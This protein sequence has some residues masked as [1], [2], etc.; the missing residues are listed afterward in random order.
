M[1]RRPLIAV[2]GP[3]GTGKTGIALHVAEAVEAEIISVDSRQAYRGM[4][5]GTAAP[6]AAELERVPHHG[7]G[8]LAPG[9]RYGAGRFGRLSR[10]WMA[11][12]R[13]RNREPMLVGGTGF[14][15]RSLVRP[16]FREPELDPDRRRRL[17]A[18]IEGREPSRLAD[19]VRALD[20]ALAD[21]LTVLDPQRAQRALEIAL[22]TGRPLTWWQRHGVPEAEPVD[23]LPFVLER[24]PEEH[25]RRLRRRAELMLDG[26]WREEVEH[27]LDAGYGRASIPF[28]TIGYGSVAEWLGG[29]ISRDDAL[30]C[31]LRDTWAYARRQRT[32]F[33]HQMPPGAIRLDAAEAPDVLAER[34][35]HAAR[36][37]RR[38]SNEG[39]R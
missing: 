35:V 31:I 18:W 19:W 38:D 24:A 25:R 14:F 39:K 30:A 26:G 11:E 23:A 10:D 29:G 13:G 27:L 17:E 21:R 15:Y 37:D 5:V 33:R 9:E 12:I 22:L 16:I 36:G 1:M 6:T 32:W 3:T 7:V 20:P 28:R 34:I 8:F 2:L 4:T